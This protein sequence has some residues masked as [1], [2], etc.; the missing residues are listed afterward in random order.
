MHC[1]KAGRIAANNLVFL[2]QT[3]AL[4]AIFKRQKWWNKPT[5]LR[6]DIQK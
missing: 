1:E 2:L 4:S 3:V 5:G 6:A